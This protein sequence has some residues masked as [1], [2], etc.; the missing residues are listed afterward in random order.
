[1]NIEDVVKLK[2][3]PVNEYKPYIVFD[4]SER[5]RI[6]ANHSSCDGTLLIGKVFHIYCDCDCHKQKNA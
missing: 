2:L 3:D 4:T 5:C 6:W 1:M